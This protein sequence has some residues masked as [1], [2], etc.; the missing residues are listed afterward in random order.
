MR[1]QTGVLGIPQDPRLG[2]HSVPPTSGPILPLSRSARDGARNRDRRGAARTPSGSPLLPVSCPLRV[3]RAAARGTETGA[4]PRERHQVVPCSRRLGPQTGP[5]SVPPG[6]R[7]E[8]PSEVPNGGSRGLPDGVRAAP[9][10]S[11][12]RAPPRAKRARGRKRGAGDYLMAFARPRADLGSARRRV[13]NAK[14]AE[15]APTLGGRY[16][17]PNGGPGECPVPPFGTS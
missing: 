5:Q 3:S 11:R 14:A 2:P 12:F 8:V 9:R 15:S 16:E 13:R 17:V 4:E 6:G 7:S 10:R 1:S